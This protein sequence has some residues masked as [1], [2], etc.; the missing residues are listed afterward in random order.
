MRY[1]KHFENSDSFGEYYLL[2]VK[3]IIT[4]I[5]NN[6][7]EIQELHRQI[8]GN[9]LEKNKLYVI[10]CIFRFILIDHMVYFNTLTID[11]RP[12]N[13]TP[14]NGIVKD[15]KFYSSSTDFME[16]GIKIYFENSVSKDNVVDMSNDIKVYDNSKLDFLSRLRIDAKTKRFDL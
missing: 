6:L 8:V 15:I 5:L 2:D 12:T 7:T 13:S 4:T 16:C 11:G 1:L 3:N 14:I 9:G 10:N